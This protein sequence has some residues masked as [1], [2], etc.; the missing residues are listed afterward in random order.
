MGRIGIKV[1]IFK[2]E[3]LPELI[4]EEEELAPIQV[5]IKADG[6]DTVV[7][8]GDLSVENQDEHNEKLEKIAVALSGNLAVS[9]TKAEDGATSQ[10]VS[11][12]E[13]DKT[14]NANGDDKAVS[15]ENIDASA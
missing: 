12:N 14:Q 11:G 2:G 5:T 1:W 3:I 9:E 4:E 6:E 7:S 8:G 10:D 13:D 15:E